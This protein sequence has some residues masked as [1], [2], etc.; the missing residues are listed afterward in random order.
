MI[1]NPDEHFAEGQAQSIVDYA[2]EEDWLVIKT[3]DTPS[4]DFPSISSKNYGIRLNKTNYV[5]PL[6][7]Y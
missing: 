2:K 1:V 5:S 6:S 4:V 3:N 7:Q